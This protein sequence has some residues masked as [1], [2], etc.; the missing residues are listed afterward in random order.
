MSAFRQ[1]EDL[2]KYYQEFHHRAVT[3]YILV[4]GFFIAGLMATP[5]TDPHARV[6][7][8]VM[9]AFA[10]LVGLIFFYYMNV[11]GARIDKLN[12]YLSG[13]ES[14]LPK[15]WRADHRNI[16]FGLHGVGAVFILVIL[17]ALQAALFSLAIVK[18]YL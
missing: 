5:A 2:A 9:L 12:S 14:Q 6:W 15:D 4:L 13:D 3:W 7:I 17:L 11:Y 16:S 18:F 10:V 1:V 8:G